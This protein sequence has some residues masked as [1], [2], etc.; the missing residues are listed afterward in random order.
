MTI[1]EIISTSAITILTLVA[2]VIG[3]QVVIIL[4]QMQK[5]LARFDEVLNSAEAT[6]QKFAAPVTGIAGLVEGVR[7]SSKIIE[8]ITSV[9]NRNH[10]RE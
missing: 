3:I 8:I 9:L 1:P 6:I 10:D 5:S 7:Q 4:K 2:V